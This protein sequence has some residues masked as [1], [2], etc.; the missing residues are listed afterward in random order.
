LLLACAA[1]FS[2]AACTSSDNLA[3]SSGGSG[4]LP[5]SEQTLPAGHPTVDPKVA[6]L[7]VEALLSEADLDSSWAQGSHA[8]DP[9]APIEL[10]YC[11]KTLAPLPWTHVAQFANEN[12]GNLMI[13]IM[14]KFPDE[15][16]AQA[17]LK[18]QRDATV[19]CDTWSSGSGADKI[20][21]QIESTEVVDFGDEGFAQK[22]TTQ[23]GDPP[24][25]STDFA[26]LVRRGDVVILIDEGGA[27]DMDGADALATAR[28]AVDKLDEALKAQSPATPTAGV[29]E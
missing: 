5:S 21:W 1:L 4:T 16:A 9:L 26:V 2:A 8:D 12:T 18:E 7:P 6:E 19:S 3:P 10:D 28:K 15:A 29:E 27:G 24:Q 20:N 25:T 11:G 22:S 23:A 17:A 14:S 13:E